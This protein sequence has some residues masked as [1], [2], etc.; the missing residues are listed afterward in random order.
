MKAI[1]NR[2]Q[3]FRYACLLCLSK[4]KFCS[5]CQAY[6]VFAEFSGSGTKSRNRGNVQAYC[7]ECRPIYLRENYRRDGKGL[8]RV[9]RKS[10]SRNYGLTQNE[11]QVMFERQMGLCALCGQ[12]PEA[13]QIL[14]V[15][16]CQ[17]TKLVRERL[18]PSCHKLLG[19]ARDTPEILKKAM[20]SLK[21][22][23]C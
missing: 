14:Q 12:A 23:A 3:V 17:R 1:R 8:E 6:K 16:H 11:Y 5:R 22:H 2:S 7:R 15:D 18:C 9:R 19:N 10:L 4:G 21:K 13:G 20:A